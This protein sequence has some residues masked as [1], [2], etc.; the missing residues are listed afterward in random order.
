M[1]K[2]VEEP[3]PEVRAKV[4]S[5]QEYEGAV[6]RLSMQKTM[7][8]TLKT[9]PEQ[10][11]A[12]QPRLVKEVPKVTQEQMD[13]ILERLQSPTVSAAVAAETPRESPL[14]NNPLVRTA[15]GR[16]LIMST[17]Q[18]NLLMS[19]AAT[20]AAVVHGSPSPPRR[21]TLMSPP[22][23]SFFGTTLAAISDV[24]EHHE[25]SPAISAVPSVDKHEPSVPVSG[26]KG[27]RR[28]DS[29]A[30]LEV[31]MV[32]EEGTDEEEEEEEKS[33][34]TTTTNKKPVKSPA[35]KPAKTPSPRK[36]VTPVTPV[37][38]SP[39]K[40]V[41]SATPV[42]I[43]GAHGGTGSRPATPNNSS[44]RRH[45]APTPTSPSNR[46]TAT[47]PVYQ[48]P[49]TISRAV[50]KSTLPTAASGT[51]EFVD[52]FEK[53]LAKTMAMLKPL[54]E[55][56]SAPARPAAVA[57]PVPTPAPAVVPVSVI[58]PISPVA[59][60]TAVFPTV[61]NT[62]S[63]PFTPIIQ[64]V[65]TNSVEV[66]LPETAMQPEL[67]QESL[68]ETQSPVAPSQLSQPSST[69]E[70]VTDVSWKPVEKPEEDVTA[71]K[72]FNEFTKEEGV[73][74]VSEAHRLEKKESILTVGDEEDDENNDD[75]DDE[76]DM[77]A[78]SMSLTSGSGEKKKRKK[79]KKKGSKK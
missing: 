2:K 51:G 74:I 69:V 65:S 7:S 20:G 10:L 50:P 14:G 67:P 52:E 49:S 61:S 11:E 33:R 43:R 30:D 41:P 23:A 1:H 53:K 44:A 35:S 42:S 34:R 17:S 18:F 12:V 45:S 72:T 40:P 3:V 27:T 22:R 28:I 15:S 46:T 47:R 63:E 29:L 79:K 76:V 19:S 4:M 56:R 70:T 77:Q 75:E 13:E 38:T 25:D 58:P 60:L 73:E 24:E 57:A 66:T 36:S 55:I 62:A 8:F 48:P 71:P 31:E 21:H 5:P 68:L 39:K 78:S 6:Q 9:D 37:R 16:S 59:S 26:N 64:A 32:E 54:D